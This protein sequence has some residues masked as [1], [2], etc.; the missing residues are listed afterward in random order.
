MNNELLTMNLLDI[1]FPKKCVGCTRVGSYFCLECKNKI[2]QTE[3]VCPFC[4]RPSL[5]GLTHPICKRKLGLDG[6][7]SLGIYQD[8]LKKAIQ[9]IKYRYI[10]ELSE[11]L[12]NILIDYWLKYQPII[13][14]TIKKDQGKSWGI[15]AV[16]LHW[17]RENWRGFNQS[18]LL[19]QSLSKKLGLDYLDYLKRTR[20]TKPQVGLKSQQRKENV[21]G[22]FILATN[23]KLQ[24]KNLILIDD[25][26]TTGSTLKECSKVLKKGGAKKVWALTLAR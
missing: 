10:S 19:G 9:K 12:I 17:K 2:K 25:V 13:L 5:G 20:Q 23:Q 18:E 7:W 22:A 14:E 4:E 8:P 26:W 1:F 21:K 6:L 11:I 24:T 16:P 3:L 15:V